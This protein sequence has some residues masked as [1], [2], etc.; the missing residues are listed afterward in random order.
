MKIR[1]VLVI[2]LSLVFILCSKVLAVESNEIPF[3]LKI[4]N[5]SNQSIDR[6]KFVMIPKNENNPMPEGSKDKEYSF[7]LDSAGEYTIPKINFDTPGDY[8]Y[9]IYQVKGNNLQYEYDTSLYH[10]II[11]VVNSEDFTNLET[12]VTVTKDGTEEKYDKIVFE[13]TYF[14]PDVNIPDTS[15]INLLLTIGVFL[16]SLYYILRKIRVAINK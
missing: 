14:P 13:N 2:I 1:N 4:N 6:F 15:D 3:E 9:E 5:N 10:I 7:T 11:T 12:L 16:S 8:E